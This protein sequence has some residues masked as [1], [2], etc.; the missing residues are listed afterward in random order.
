[1]KRSC[2]TLFVLLNTLFGSSQLHISYDIKIDTADLSIFGVSIKMQNVPDEFQLAMI[3][4]PE[5]DDRYWR[6]VEDL[7]VQTSAGNGT[8][9]KIENAVWKIKIPGNDAIIRYNIRLPND[10]QSRAAWRPFLAATGG[11]VGGAHSYMYMVGHEKQPSTVHLSIPQGWEIATGMEQTREKHTFLCSGVFE[12]TDCPFM[13][14]KF[15]KWDFEISGVSHHIA[16]WLLPDA[17]PFD[18][19]RLTGAIKKITTQALKIFGTFPYRSYSF[20]LEDGAY[21]ALEHASSVTVGIPTA[22]LD[23]EFAGYLNEIDHEYFH[24]WNLVKIKP[25][26]YGGVSYRKQP[27]SKGL[28][29]SEG[30]TMYYADLIAYRAGLPINDTTRIKHLERLLR[31][32]YNSPGHRSI[33]PE[34]VSMAE[35]GPPGMLGDYAGS[36]HLQGELLATML[37]LFII[38]ATNAGSSLD[39]V[40]KEMMRKYSGE[41]GFTTN[42]IE[43]IVSGVSGKN[44][45]QFFA[46]HVKGNKEFPLNDYLALMGWKFEL[47]WRVA[48]EAGGNQLPDLRIYPLDDEASPVRIGITDPKGIWAKAGIHT[49]D[50]VAAING[51]RIKNRNDFW[52]LIKNLK[53]GDSVAVEISKPWGIFKTNVLI[54]TYEQPVINLHRMDSPGIRQKKV[55][56]KWLEGL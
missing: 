30:F 45:H 36:A 52:K 5:Y 49:G 12:L 13:I 33:S 11:L 38:D 28:W 2:L 37:D 47:G 44:V 16:Y 23:D 4:H 32:Y 50:Q 8:I 26:E 55:E 15:K 29:F 41:K 54:D 25:V 1:M 27:L 18:E 42:D 51:E 10:G 19:E 53:I 6:Y 7:S 35:Y 14:G 46:D 34:T 3:A 48:T 22:K 9:E 39:D 21:G 17:R 31:R 43:E 56:E 24:N 40:M 20:L